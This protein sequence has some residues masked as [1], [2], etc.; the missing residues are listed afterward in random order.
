MACVTWQRTG[1]PGMAA[2]S[3]RDGAQAKPLSKD[4]AAQRKALVTAAGG[5][6][7]VPAYCATLITSLCRMWPQTARPVDGGA[8]VAT[9]DRRRD[10]IA[11]RCP[12]YPE[13]GG[14]TPPTV[15]PLPKPTVIHPLPPIPAPVPINP[16]SGAGSR[17]DGSGKPTVHPLPA[18]SVAAPGPAT[19]A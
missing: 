6:D 1:Q 7:T 15:R 3:G 5:P 12:F 14:G 4:V 18:Q 11:I 2:S 13:D 10:V 17:N 8:P 16:G 9:T 19:R